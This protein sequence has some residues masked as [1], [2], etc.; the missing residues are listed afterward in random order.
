MSYAQHQESLDRLAIYKEWFLKEILQTRKR[1]T[2]LVLPITN[3]QPDY[4]DVPPG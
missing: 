4:R 2:L 3:Q 1:N